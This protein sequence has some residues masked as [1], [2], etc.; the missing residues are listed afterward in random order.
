M[1]RRKHG[2]PVHGIVLLDKPPGLS[3]NHALQRVRRLFNARKAGHTGTLDPFAT[4][5]LPVC[6]GEATKTTAFMLD[7]DKAYHAVAAF[8]V[9]TT[10]GDPEG[11]AT[12]R[13]PVPDLTSDE[14]E[15]ALDGFR[16]PLEQVPPMY[17]ALKRDGKPLYELARQ[18]IEVERAA[19]SVTIHRLQLEQWQTPQL[20]FEVVCSKGTYIRT[21]GT[22]IAIALGSCAHLAALRRLWVAPFAQA[23]MVSMEQ[24]EQAAQCGE[25]SRHLLAPDAALPHWP[26]L[27]LQPDGQQRF[28]QGNPF[29]DQGTEALAAGTGVRVHNGQG[30]VLGLG[31]IKAGQLWPRRVFQPG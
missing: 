1:S 18:G 2:D 3:S 4:G 29:A 26:V 28:M 30:G 27:V 25:L 8:G 10:T 13:C 9:E 15:R 19:R 24:L 22:D 14:I 5:M 16:G 23:A 17:S 21:L 6:L 7:A 11:E 31:V 12:R 20:R